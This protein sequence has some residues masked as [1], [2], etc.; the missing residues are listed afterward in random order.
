M[1]MLR[2]TCL[3]LYLVGF[4]GCGQPDTSTDPAGAANRQ[5]RA[6]KIEQLKAKSEAARKA[7]R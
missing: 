6:D 1:K 5:E 2:W 4:S 7:K 3:A